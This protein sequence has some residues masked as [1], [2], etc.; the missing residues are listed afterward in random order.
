MRHYYVTG[1]ERV[2]LVEES[3]PEPGAGQVRVKLAYTA[4]S[5]GSNLYV[6][7]TGGYGGRSA[8]REEAVYMGSAVVEAVGKEVTRYGAG[9]RVAMVGVGHQAY[10]VFAED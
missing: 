6:F 7:R 4:L 9:D 1:P 3:I 5:P 8:G 10:A 2:E